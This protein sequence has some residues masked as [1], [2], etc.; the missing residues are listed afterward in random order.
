[1]SNEYTCAMCGE[2]L[3]KGWTDE[4]ALAEKEANGFQEMECDLVCDD[5]YHKVMD[6]I[7]Q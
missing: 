6:G 7:L 5:C 1:M 4:E 2:T 3:T